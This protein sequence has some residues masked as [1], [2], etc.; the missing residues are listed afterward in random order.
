M[1]RNE[2]NDRAWLNW[3]AKVRIIIITFLFGIE[4]AISR[5]TPTNVPVRGFISTILL[6]YTI[7]IFQILLISLWRDTQ[8]QVRLQILTDMAFAT[9]IVYLTGGIETSF[10]F[11]YPLIIIVASIQLT[12]V[13]AYLTAGLSFL[14]FSSTL[15]LTQ[16]GI[17]RSYAWGLPPDDKSLQMVVVVNLCAY[18]AVAYLASSLSAK[19][20]QVD[21]EALENLQALHENIINSMSG[22]L[23]T[24]DLQGRVTFLNASGEKLLERRS[25]EVLGH[26]AEELFLDRV[27]GVESAQAK[28][29]L[30][31]LTPNGEEKTFGIKVSTLRVP[32]RGTLG[33][34]YSFA[35]LTEIRRLEREVR[36]HDRLSAVGRMAAGIA[37]EIR[38]PL[39]SIA[40]SVKV[41]ATISALTEEQRT[42]VDVVTRESDRL[43]D[44]ITNFLFYS[45]EKSYQFAV[46]DLV[47]LLDDT[48][49]LLENRPPALSSSLASGTSGSASGG[50][51]TIVRQYESQEA[52]ARVNGDKM[53]QV[54]WNICENA[55]RA[56]P[57]GG[58]LT[59]R[60]FSENG[61]WIISFADTGRGIRAHQ[62]D[63][64]FE[65]FQSGFENGTGLGLAIVYQIVQAHQGKISVRSAPGEGAEF[66]LE[67][68]QAAVV[69][70]EQEAGPGSAEKVK[71][72]HG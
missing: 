53:K 69:E 43:N 32:D 12:R 41:L 16:Y 2:I 65:P 51:I 4:L 67:L 22:G 28:G 44:I 59:V 25:D 37:H 57:D 68:A 54:F 5:L 30:R 48:L 35:D 64:V 19:L 3:L 14:L 38:N 9:A 7:S 55:A 20:R 63:K 66:R 15:E 17:L 10:N 45:R 21:V 31:S 71:V 56:M 49:T 34:V 46:E 50:G 52:L 47:P 24:T 33:Y 13:W 42:L 36:M 18:M 70:D 29:E 62:L 39:S 27:P 60:L 11:L 1:L 72:A 23:I 26:K 61:Q 8:V 40:G 58:T 6:W